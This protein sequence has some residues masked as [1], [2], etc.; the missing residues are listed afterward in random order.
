M[1]VRIS[2]SH[3]NIAQK[4]SRKNEII[5]NIYGDIQPVNLFFCMCK[6][7]NKLI[8]GNVHGR[9]LSSEINTKKKK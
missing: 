3:G 7:Y 2:I 4:A 8:K 9:Y 6:G 5:K 1:P